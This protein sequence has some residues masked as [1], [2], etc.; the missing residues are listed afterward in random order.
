MYKK[1]QSYRKALFTFGSSL[2]IQNHADDKLMDCLKKL[3]ALQNYRSAKIS[4]VNKKELCIESNI[5]E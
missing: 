1:N 2:I 3:N 4:A 5:C